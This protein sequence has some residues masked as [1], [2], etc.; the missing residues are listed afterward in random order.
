MMVEIKVLTILPQVEVFSFG[1][2]NI[3]RFASFHLNCRDIINHQQN[4]A[5]KIMVVLSVSLLWIDM[6]RLNKASNLR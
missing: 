5:N 1:F 3:S 4:W 6:R 2:F